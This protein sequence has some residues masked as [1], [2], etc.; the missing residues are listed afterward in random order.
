MENCQEIAGL[1][2]RWSGRHENIYIPFM[3]NIEEE[4]DNQSKFQPSDLGCISGEEREC[5][6]H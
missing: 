1:L 5:T 4:L 3:L 2:A 6:D